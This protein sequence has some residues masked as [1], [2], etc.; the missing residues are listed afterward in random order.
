MIA[1][2]DILY[3]LAFT[4]MDLIH[5]DNDAAS[6]AVFNRYLAGAS[7]DNLDG[8]AVL[9]LFLS[10][11]AAIRAHVV[12]T[13]SEQ[14]VD[15]QAAWHEAKRYFD[16]ALRLANP[17]PPLLTAIGGLSGT[18]KSVLAFGLAGHDRAAAGR[19]HCPLGCHAQT[20]VRRERND[21]SA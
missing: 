11:R 9:P 7:D 16:L 19:G 6:N 12:F 2:T 8:L 13:K 21:A 17:K 4:L 15:G 20:S 18:G 5:F 1:T 3:D 14:M 10:M